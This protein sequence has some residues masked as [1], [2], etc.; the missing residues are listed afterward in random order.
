MVA[1]TACQ[2]SKSKL[3]ERQSRWAQRQRGR[4]R[5]QG[6]PMSDPAPDPASL[7]IADHHVGPLGAPAHA[8]GGLGSGRRGAARVRLVCDNDLS[9]LNQCI[10]APRKPRAAVRSPPC[11]PA[12]CWSSPAG[13][14]RTRHRAG[15]LGASSGATEPLPLPPPPHTPAA[16]CPLDRA[17]LPHRQCRWYIADDKGYV[18][19]RDTFNYGTGCCTSGALHSC[20]T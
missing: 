8:A 11:R 10:G 16:A 13:A 4:R 9:C 19:P 2:E 6:S 3:H 14:A 1:C 20:D 7:H 12:G 5:Q 18:C 15:A 17:L